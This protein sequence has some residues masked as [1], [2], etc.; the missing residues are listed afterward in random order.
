MGVTNR[1]HDVSEQKDV[2]TFSWGGGGVG[3]SLIA[4][5][6]TTCMTSPLPSPG[7]I[8]TVMVSCQG[9]SVVPT[10]SLEI[11]RFIA[12]AGTTTLVGLGSSFLLSAFSISGP[13]SVSLVAAGNTLLNV[14]AGDCLQMRL[15]VNTSVIPMMSVVIQKSQ[16]IV[17]R[18][19]TS[20]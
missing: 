2:F 12:G 15:G 13:L 5:V 11:V 7:V 18:F 17:S 8:E 3:G 16:D 9:A 20:T 14:L 1:A 6:G 4:G 19:G 10:S